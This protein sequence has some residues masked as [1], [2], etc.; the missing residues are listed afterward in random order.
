[1][2]QCLYVLLRSI[3]KDKFNLQNPAISIL[4]NQQWET[5]QGLNIRF[6]PQIMQFEIDKMNPKLDI[7]Y[8]HKKFHW[9]L[10]SNKQEFCILNFWKFRLRLLDFFFGNYFWPQIIQ[11]EYNKIYVAKWI[12]I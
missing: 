5:K 9:N 12:E 2:K 10:K 11:V 7:K 8:N 1:M 4:R 3:R 6:W